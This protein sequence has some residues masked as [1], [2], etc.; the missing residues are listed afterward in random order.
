MEMKTYKVKLTRR[1]VVQEK[2]IVSVMAHDQDEALNLAMDVGR[3]EVDVDW[4]PS[5]NPD[6]SVYVLWDDVEV[7]P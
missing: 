4:I 1:K 3:D 7:M 5:G 2:T 6:I